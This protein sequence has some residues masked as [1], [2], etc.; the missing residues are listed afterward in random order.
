MSESIDRIWTTF[1]TSLSVT[2]EPADVMGAAMMIRG[3]A[4]EGRFAF[5][6]TVA[7]ALL[8]AEMLSSNVR[9]VLHEVSL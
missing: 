3:D 2:N 4:E 6:L 7:E 5:Q 8:L 1:G 9:E